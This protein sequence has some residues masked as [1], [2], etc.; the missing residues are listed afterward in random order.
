MFR[1]FLVAVM[2]A[3]G[4]GATSTAT[5]RF[6]VVSEAQEIQSGQALPSLEIPVCERA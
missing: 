2:I 1:R 3:V 6:I 5:G 4:A